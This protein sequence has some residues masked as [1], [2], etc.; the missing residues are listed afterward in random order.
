MVGFFRTLL[1]ENQGL[2]IEYLRTHPLNVNRVS[3]A[4]HRIAD[5]TTGRQSDSEDFRFAKARLAFLTAPDV[6]ALLIPEQQLTTPPLVYR[7]ALIHISLD[8]T[9]KA[10]T[11]L[12]SAQQ[13]SRHPWLALAL[14]EAYQ[15]AGDPQRALKQTQSLLKLYPG[16]LPVTLAYAQLSLDNKGDLNEVITLLKH[17][18]QTDD[19]ASLHKMLARTYFL[20]GQISAAL[21]STGNQYLLQGYTELAL[22]QYE[23]AK[24]QSDAGDSA[25]QRLQKKTEMLKTRIAN[26]NTE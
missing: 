11:M 18:L 25:K 23:N 26:I 2:Q 4:E 24:N 21:E 12:R 5:S 8:D 22:Q 9:E 14:A 20:N 19:K 3:E 7:Q 1:E 15:Q 16:Y 10:V 6:S 17:Q 13:R